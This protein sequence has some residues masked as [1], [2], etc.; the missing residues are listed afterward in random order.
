MSRTHTH[1]A[2]THAHTREHT[3]TCTYMRT[4]IRAHTHTRTH[5][6]HT[7][8]HTCRY[9]HAHTRAHIHAHIHTGISFSHGKKEILPLTTTWMKLEGIMLSKMSER[10]RQLTYVLTYVWNL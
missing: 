6:I 1:N 10:K 5:A 8:A 9:T 2:H 3:H 4:H 7:H